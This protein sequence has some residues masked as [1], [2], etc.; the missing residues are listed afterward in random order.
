MK[1]N[2]ESN[3]GA[4]VYLILTEEEVRAFH[5]ITAFKTDAFTSWR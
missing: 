5:D 1:S 3:I 4:I 2:L